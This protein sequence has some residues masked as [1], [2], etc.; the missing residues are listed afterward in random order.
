MRHSVCAIVG[1]TNGKVHFTS[2]RLSEASR[3]LSL[4]EVKSF[5]RRQCEKVKIGERGVVRGAVRSVL[6]PVNAPNTQVIHLSR[7]CQIRAD[8]EARGKY[9]AAVCT[10]S[11]EWCERKYMRI[12]WRMFL[13]ITTTMDVVNREKWVHAGDWTTLHR[14]FFFL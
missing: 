4:P 8:K 1:D 7:P 3:N 13:K 6:C 5:C 9:S 12:K 11:V 10:Q 14:F 2:G